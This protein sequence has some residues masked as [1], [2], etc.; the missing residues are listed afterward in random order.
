MAL[1]VGS[2]YEDALASVDKAIWHDEMET[3][4]VTAIK[5]A[6]DRE[7]NTLRRED[8]HSEVTRVKKY[9][10]APKSKSSKTPPPSKEEKKSKPRKTKEPRST[11]PYKRKGKLYDD[12]DLTSCKSPNCN[13]GIA[14]LKVKS[15]F[16]ET[17]QKAR[18]RPHLLGTRTGL[19]ALPKLITNEL[20]HSL[21]TFFVK[22]ITEEF[23]YRMTPEIANSVLD[24]VKGE[25]TNYL[26]T[27]LSKILDPTLKRSLHFSVPAT[28]NAVLP[29]QLLD[30]SQNILT[31]ILTR[32]IT[33]ALVPSLTY[34]LSNVRDLN[35]YSFD[36]AL[37]PT[38]P[39]CQKESRV[40][41]S[42]VGMADYYSAYF[43]DYYADYYL[44]KRKLE[45]M[46]PPDYM[47][48]QDE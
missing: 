16:L 6:M 45:N 47:G 7:E 17:A 39:K 22:E 21:T 34:S 12:I 25:T 28:F 3:K 41:Y 38:G 46:D 31:N 44:D 40:L 5:H 18:G 32:S 4:N 29:G 14:E 20:L 35:K 36:C 43:S 42:K 37:T 9:K 10:P 13:P 27:R 30:N 33:H 19:G 23:T 2:L 15:S 11:L 1:Y 8:L 24:S 26:A 48:M